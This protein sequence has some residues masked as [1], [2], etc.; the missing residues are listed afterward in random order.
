MTQARGF[1]CG[2]SSRSRRMCS[3]AARSNPSRASVSKETGTERSFVYVSAR[4]EE[5]PQVR[6]VVG[7]RLGLVLPAEDAVE[8]ALAQRPVRLVLLP[9]R[10]GESTRAC[11]SIPLRRALRP[12]GRDHRRAPRPIAS[13]APASSWRSSLKQAEASAARSPSSLRSPYSSRTASI[14]CAERRGKDSPRKSTR[15]ARNS[16][17][18][19]VGA[20][21]ELGDDDA[22][23]TRPRGGGRGARARLRSPRPPPCAETRAARG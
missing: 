14:A 13:P 20:L 18:E 15:A 21:G 16:F 6:H 7:R 8:P 11:R 10:A 3:S 12:T 22:A 5:P 1:F 4:G 19:A 2:R 17:L 9:R 23:Q